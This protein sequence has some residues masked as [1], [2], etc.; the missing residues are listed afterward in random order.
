MRYLIMIA[1]FALVGTAVAEDTPNSSTR[2]LDKSSPSLVSPRDAASGMSTGKRQHAAAPGDTGSSTGATRAQD[3]N[4][5][6]SNTTALRGDTTGDL[7]RD[8]RPDVVTCGNGVDN[9]CDD[10][11]RAASPGDYNG[12]R[13]NRSGEASPRNHNASRS[14]RSSG[15]R[16][17]DYNSSRSNNSSARL[18]PDS[19]GDS[20]L[21]EVR[22]SVTSDDCVSDAGGDDP[23]L[24]KRPGR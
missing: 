19:D 11:G 4:S 21:R 20:T 24:R 5:S 13:S 9:D 7:D 6:R 15:T 12:T 17:Q 18:D 16:A 8:G 2:E 14:N 23:I 10:T 1:S 3:Y 22:C